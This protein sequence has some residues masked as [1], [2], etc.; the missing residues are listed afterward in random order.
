[1]CLKNRVTENDRERIFHPGLTPQVAEIARIGTPRTPS[2]SLTW[3]PGLKPG[4]FSGIPAGGWIGNGA[5]GTQTS[6]VI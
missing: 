6:T 3:E 1:M 5:V 4:A 2:R